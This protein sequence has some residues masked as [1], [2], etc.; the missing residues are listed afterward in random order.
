[1][2]YEVDKKPSD[3]CRLG[4]ACAC[5]QD[6][7]IQNVAKRGFTLVELLVVI[8]IIGVL[9]SLLLPAVQAAREAARRSQCTNNLKQLQLGVLNYESAVGKLPPGSKVKVPDDCENGNGSCRGIPVY[10]L[11]MPYLESVAI[12][13]EVRQT[14]SQRTDD[15]WAWTAMFEDDSATPHTRI[16]V[17]ICPSLS[18]NTDWESLGPRRDYYGVAGGARNRLPRPDRQ[19]ITRNARGWVYTNGVFQMMTEI[20]L[21]Q[22]TDGT[23]STMS[24]GESKH[25]A[26]FGYAEDSGAFNP[27]VGGPGCWWHGGANSSV[28]DPNTPSTYNGHSYGRCIRTTREAM[29]SSL[30]PGMAENEEN[31]APFGSDHPGGAQFAFVDGHVTFLQEDMDLELYQALST[32]DGGETVSTSDL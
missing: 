8:A 27:E 29:N 28:F 4:I 12:P 17:F 10:I 30:W 1:M 22:I 13:D 21:S 18:S 23:S 31:D 32:Y 6:Y 25:P 16:P 2:D 15:G 9:V 24:I 5:H 26:R 14:L 7:E 11:I 19:P 20:S 3:S